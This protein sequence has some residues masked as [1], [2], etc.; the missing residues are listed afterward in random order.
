MEE[1]SEF[2]K[3]FKALMKEKQKETTNQAVSASS[4]DVESEEEKEEKEEEDE[5][6]E[7]EAMNEEEDLYEQPDLGKGLSGVLN[8]LRSQ[9]SEDL[10]EEAYGR[11]NDRVIRD[12]ESKG[13]NKGRG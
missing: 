8:L 9:K 4:L 2:T 7:E 5:I 6:K 13:I 1:V 12:N 11:R 10:E 3:R